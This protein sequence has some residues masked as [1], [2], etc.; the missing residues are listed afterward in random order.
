MVHKLWEGE[1]QSDM[2]NISSIKCSK[3]DGEMYIVLTISISSLSMCCFCNLL[4]HIFLKKWLISV[5]A[6]HIPFGNKSRKANG[7][8]VCI[9]TH[10][11]AHTT[12]F[13]H[14]FYVNSFF[15]SMSKVVRIYHPK[16]LLA[17]LFLY[18]DFAS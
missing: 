7:M 12:T 4:E 3:N 16:K 15:F 18:I 11:N 9:N 2:L 1:K 17:V 13:S 14:N 8:S 6:S 5:S 10:P